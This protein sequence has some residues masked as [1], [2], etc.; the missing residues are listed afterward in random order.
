MILAPMQG[1]TEVI[2]RRTYER[3]FPGVF[4]SAI[5]PFISLTQGVT[6]QRRFNIHSDRYADILPENNE[7][8]IPVVPQ[9]LGH[10]AE[11]FVE[12]TNILYDMGYTEVN[13]NIGCPMRA[14][15][16]K[17]RGCGI[18][19]YPDEVRA[20]LDDVIPRIKPRLSIKMRIGHRE[21]DEIFALVPVINDYPV[22]SVTIH[23]RLG[24]QQYNGHPD[25]DTFGRVLPLIKH[26]VIYNGD[27]CSV[28]DARNIRLRFPHV[29]DIMIG[30][31]ALYTPT[32]PLDI[33]GQKTSDRLSMSK[34]FVASL[35]EA[36]KEHYP[37]TESATRKTKEY[38]CLLWKS[39]CND[40]QAARAVLRERDFTVVDK[41]ISR[42]TQ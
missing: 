17:H 7:G 12:L 29:A 6:R 40:E 37:S 28:A 21:R 11:E 30:R 36:I 27:L 24:R 38:W 22:A 10:E 16:A 3:C 19:P 9:L 5:A 4:D 32:L 2:F 15:A 34:R 23:P 41:M 8:S 13:W 26:P 14:I 18:L 42:F 31:A 25:L 39:V 1:L 20:L 33:K 35:M